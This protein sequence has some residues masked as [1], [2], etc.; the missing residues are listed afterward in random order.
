MKETDDPSEA[1]IKPDLKVLDVNQK[2]VLYTMHLAIHY[3]RREGIE[4]YEEISLWSSL[5]AWRGIWI[6]LGY[7]SMIFRSALGG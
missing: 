5:L 7:R 3:C 2:E 1:P 4:E 6:N